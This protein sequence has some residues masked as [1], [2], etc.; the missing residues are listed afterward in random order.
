[1]VQQQ[2][3]GWMGGAAAPRPAAAAPPPP[4]A[5]ASGGAVRRPTGSDATQ[6][7]LA[8]LAAVNAPAAAGPARPWDCGVCTY[9]HDGPEAEF[10]LCAVC[11]A[12]KHG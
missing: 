12:E 8:T 11:G 3:I 2:A 7:G 6:A 1:V 10:L 5:A 4:S 9:R